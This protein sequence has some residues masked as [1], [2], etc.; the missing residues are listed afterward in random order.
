MANKFIAKKSISINAPAS[1]VWKALTDPKLVKQ[2]FFGVDVI[3]D[4]KQ[5]SPIIYQGVWEG[6]PFEDKGNVLKIEPEKLLLTNHWSPS[7]GLPDTPENYHNVRYDLVPEGRGTKLTITQDNNATEE[8]KDHSEQNWG[9][10]LEGM[11]KLLE[12]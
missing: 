4:W 1:K 11:K 2:Y 7:S 8:E 3:T 5:G 12:K 10:I 6:K 9:A